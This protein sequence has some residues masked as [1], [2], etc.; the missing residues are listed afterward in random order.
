[1]D[2]NRERLSPEMIKSNIASV[3]GLILEIKFYHNSHS[4]IFISN[5]RLRAVIN[6]SKININF[7]PENVAENY[8][9]AT[10]QYFMLKF[11]LPG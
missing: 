8:L 4:M 10:Q 9:S 11:I 7:N 6:D 3:S 2:V 5:N 1:M